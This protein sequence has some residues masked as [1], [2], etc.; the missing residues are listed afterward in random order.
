MLRLVSETVRR[1]WGKLRGDIVIVPS[2]FGAPE[3][4]ARFRRVKGEERMWYVTGPGEL[5]AIA[6]IALL[7]GNLGHSTGNIRFLQPGHWEGEHEKL[8]Q[9][10]LVIVGGPRTNPACKAYLRDISRF[11]YDPEEEPWT[12]R[13]TQNEFGPWI[14]RYED[15]K[16]VDH[17]LVVKAP[18]PQVENATIM[19]A[20]GGHSLGSLLASAALLDQEMLEAI[21][22]DVGEEQFE[23]VVSTEWCE[24]D[25]QISATVEYPESL[26]GTVVED[27]MAVEARTALSGH[28]GGLTLVQAG[29]VTK[30]EPHERPKALTLNM[31]WEEVAALSPEDDA[32]VRGDV[33]MWAREDER[34]QEMLRE[35]EWV[36]VCGPNLQI[37]G[38]GSLAH[39]PDEEQQQK[40]SEE[41][42]GRTVFMVDRAPD[43]VLLAGSSYATTSWAGHNRPIVKFTIGYAWWTSAEMKKKGSLADALFDSG[44]P[45]TYVDPLYA[46]E[47]HSLTL[48]RS[49][50]APS[51]HGCI[52]TLEGYWVRCTLGLMAEDLSGAEDVVL[53]WHGRMLDRYRE[54][55]IR[56][57]KDAPKTLHEYLISI[58][59]KDIGLLVGMN[60]LAEDD[61]TPAASMLL[62][63][64]NKRT[65]VTNIHPRV[66]DASDIEGA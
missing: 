41:N 12:L 31:S 32:D 44:S 16:I 18:H 58:T 63:G 64:K 20:C 37:V 33:A 46:F 38:S 55:K 48:A 4:E 14:P 50:G 19:I 21:I 1:V 66:G 61:Y 53:R 60:V 6:R 8:M 17:G 24:D 45:H 65:T 25:P 9:A 10:S 59:G 13:D 36:A 42:E 27:L 23:L 5:Q 11:Y 35:V 54:R 47:K 22:Q 26:R 7:L 43:E 40:W 62:N 28:P 2:Y 39:W 51:T 30:A 34:V 49:P 29:A 56:R 15:D 57:K 3:E 52:G